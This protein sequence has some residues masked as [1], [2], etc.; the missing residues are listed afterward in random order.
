VKDE[1]LQLGLDDYYSVRGWTKDGIPTVEKLK[2]LNL[3]E[4]ANIVKGGES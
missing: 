3:S 1:E 2:E 4:Y